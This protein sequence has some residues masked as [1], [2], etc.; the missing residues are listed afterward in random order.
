MRT[1]EK[2]T[3]NCKR[4]HR[5]RRNGAF[6]LVEI[7]I[8]V[9][10]LGVLAAIVIPQFSTA[11]SEAHLNT[12]LGNLQ[13]LRLQIELYKVQHYDLLPGQDSFG[14]DVTEAEFLAALTNDAK[15]GAYVS[16]I[17]ENLFISAAAG[18]VAITCVKDGAADAAPIGNE[19]TGWWFNAANGDFRACSVDHIRY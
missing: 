14:D 13:T 11:T 12:L 15:Y 17:P 19:G 6:T 4:S 5:R 18:R 8:V 9:V 1:R 10:I 3:G 7:L 2:N 16:K